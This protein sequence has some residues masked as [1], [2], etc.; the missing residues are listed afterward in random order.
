MPFAV[1]HLVAAWLLGKAY[2][3]WSGKEIDHFTWGLLLLG[4]IVPDFDY[5]F[6]WF[7]GLNVHRS[8]SHS[9][10]FLFL[11]IFTTYLFFEYVF[12]ESDFAGKHNAKI[13]SLA[14]GFGVFSH[15]LLDSFFL[16]GIPLFWPWMW[17]FSFEGV[18]FS[19][20]RSLILEESEKVVRSAR[21]ALIDMFVGLLFIAWHW[22]KKQLRL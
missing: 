10:I 12:K 14:F 6:D 7:L 4:S 22:W 20:G 9:F 5:F 16:E 17:N 1:T 15:L 8:F 19:S 18:F 21:F 3:K 13:L 11:A 2:Q